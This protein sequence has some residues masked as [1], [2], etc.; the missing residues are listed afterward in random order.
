MVSELV[1]PVEEVGAHPTARDFVEQLGA[2]G[3]HR[4]DGRRGE[5]GVHLLYRGPHGGTLRVLRS[6]YG[7]ADLDLVEKAARFV[8]VTPE[9]F[10]AGPPPPPPPPPH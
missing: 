10:W 1:G 3:F 6:L 8:D 7:R 4:R 5:D 9:Q 2:W